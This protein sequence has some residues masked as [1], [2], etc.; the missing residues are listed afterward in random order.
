MRIAILVFLLTW[1]SD[2]GNVIS[3]RKL[4]NPETEKSFGIMFHSP[5]HDLLIF[6]MS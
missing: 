3:I 1:K 5:E 2:K 4:F 6:I